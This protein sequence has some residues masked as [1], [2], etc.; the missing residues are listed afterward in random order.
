MYEY[1]GTPPAHNVSLRPALYIQHPPGYWII[2]GIKCIGY[3]LIPSWVVW[4]QGPECIFHSITPVNDA[5]VNRRRCFST[6]TAEACGGTQ[7]PQLWHQPGNPSTQHFLLL[8]CYTNCLVLMLVTLHA[9][10]RETLL[11]HAG[12]LTSRAHEYEVWHCNFWTEAADKIWSPFISNCTTCLLVNKICKFLLFSP[13]LNSC[14]VETVS[15]G[16]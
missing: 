12:F 3:E 5:T 1:Y 14:Q 9:S 15:H 2:G 4:F 7:P 13:E 11:L 8:S 6:H 16:N 10:R